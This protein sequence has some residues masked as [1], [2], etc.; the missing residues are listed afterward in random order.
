M[1]SGRSSI[2]LASRKYC[3]D[4]VPFTSGSTP[5]PLVSVGASQWLQKAIFVS[6]FSINFIVRGLVIC[7]LVS[8]WRILNARKRISKP[9][10]TQTKRESEQTLGFRLE[11][12]ATGFATNNPRKQLILAHH[13]SRY[14]WQLLRE[15]RAQPILD[16]FEHLGR[17]RPRRHVRLDQVQHWPH[18]RLRIRRHVA[19]SGIRHTDEDVARQQAI[20]DLRRLTG[21]G[22]AWCDTTTDVGRLMMT[23]S[24]AALPSS[25]AD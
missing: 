24:W 12:I 21:I 6:G 13:R 25:N 19:W 5:V 15:V 11:R 2:R 17:I 8:L 20:S 22:E 16:H 23:P 18:D 1:I 3:Q 9:L 7:P 14:R 10:R 4:R